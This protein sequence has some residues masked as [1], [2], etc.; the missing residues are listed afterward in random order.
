M[1]SLGGITIEPDA[2]APSQSAQFNMRMLKNNNRVLSYKTLNIPYFP[3]EFSMRSIWSI[4]LA[5]DWLSLLNI[6]QVNTVQYEIKKKHHRSILPDHFLSKYLMY[7]LRSHGRKVGLHC[8][9]VGFHLPK[10]SLHWPK[11]LRPKKSDCYPMMQQ[12]FSPMNRYSTTIIV[13]YL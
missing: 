3:Q 9:K 2:S 4:F 13:L 1:I 12:I 7:T 11:V 8:P 5:F 6:V 10:I